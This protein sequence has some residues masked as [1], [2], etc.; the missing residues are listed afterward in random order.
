[1]GEKVFWDFKDIRRTLDICLVLLF[2][3]ALEEFVNRR[4]VYLLYMFNSHFATV[5][6]IDVYCR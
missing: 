1:M 2:S 6:S 3:K 5:E 4:V